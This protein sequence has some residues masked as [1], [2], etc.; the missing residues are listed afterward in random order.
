MSAAVKRIQGILW[1]V[2]ILFAGFAQVPAGAQVAPPAPVR[3]TVDG[4]G[5]DLFLGTFNVEAPPLSA[6][7]GIDWKKINLGAGWG[8]NVIAT[9]KEEAGVAYVSLGTRT[10]RFTIS[11]STYT[12]TDGTV[13][14]FPRAAWEPIPI[15]M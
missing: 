15:T 5:V 7:R 6:G 2:L 4:N 13:I 12:P 1:A 8:D 9:L 3:P 14:H 11:G 10:D